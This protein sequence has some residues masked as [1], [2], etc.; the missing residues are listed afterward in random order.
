M[1]GVNGEIRALRVLTT[2]QAGRIKELESLVQKC[3]AA[4]VSGDETKWDR[5]F[6]N[7]CTAVP[8]RVKRVRAGSSEPSP[9]SA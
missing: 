9:S 1:N 6:T 7:L 2:R 5:A 3:R 4:D 8:P